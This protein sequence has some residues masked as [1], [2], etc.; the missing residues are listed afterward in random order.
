MYDVVVTPARRI[1]APINLSIFV[2]GWKSPN[3]TVVKVV[4]LKYVK[5]MKLI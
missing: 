5:V 4:K 2:L 1:N 3:P